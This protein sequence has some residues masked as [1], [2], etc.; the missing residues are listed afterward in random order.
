MKHFSVVIVGAGP[1]GLCL[2]YHLKEKGIDHIIIEKKEIL[3]TWKNERWDSFDLVT[4]NWMTLLPETEKIIPKNNEFMSKNQIVNSLEKFA[5]EVNPN[6]LE[7]TVISNIS[8]EDELYYI[9]TD[10]GN[11][12]ANNVIISVGLFNNKKIPL[13]EFDT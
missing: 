5:K 9:K 13:P 10:K 3:H 7:H 2:S 4:P 1:S 6:V 8:L 11:F 12:T